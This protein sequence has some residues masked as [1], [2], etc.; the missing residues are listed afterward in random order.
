MSLRPDITETITSTSNGSA[1]SVHLA[2][3]A[4][5]EQG[6]GTENFVTIDFRVAEKYKERRPRDYN[7]IIAG[8]SSTGR[9]TSGKRRGRKGAEKK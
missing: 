2:V 4:I 9:V 6:G 7:V 8:T 1:A 5:R 3:P